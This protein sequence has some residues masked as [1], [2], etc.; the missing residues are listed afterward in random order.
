MKP[1]KFLALFVLF[2]FSLFPT[3]VASIY[4]F[5]DKKAMVDFIAQIPAGRF[6]MF[7]IPLLLITYATTVGLMYYALNIGKS[8]DKPAKS[9][10]IDD[11]NLEKK[12]AKLYN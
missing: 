8:P 12:L 2:I 1:F 7:G 11:P 3:T 4:M 6:W 9:L 10:S 5:G